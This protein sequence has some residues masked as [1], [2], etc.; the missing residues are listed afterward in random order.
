MYHTSK[1][2]SVSFLTFRHLLSGCSR[3]KNLKCSPQWGWEPY[4]LCSF[5]FSHQFRH[6]S[7][8]TD[9]LG[10]VALIL[11]EGECHTFYIM[12]VMLDSE[13]DQNTPPPNKP[14]CLKGCFDRS[15]PWKKMEKEHRKKKK[16]VL[17][18]PSICLKYKQGIN[19][20]CEGVSPPLSI[21]EGE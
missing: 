4:W 1:V 9:N 2:F 18:S 21:S 8:L 14:L 13:G 20:P 5:V 3:T 17:Y 6:K 11:Q 15:N 10:I 19:P 7:I 16:R 12:K